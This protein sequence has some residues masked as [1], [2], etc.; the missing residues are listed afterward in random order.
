MNPR[1]LYR[2]TVNAIV[3]VCE[4]SVKTP[5]GNVEVNVVHLWTSEETDPWRVLSEECRSDFVA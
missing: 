4:V 5:W 1:A 2:N 3:G